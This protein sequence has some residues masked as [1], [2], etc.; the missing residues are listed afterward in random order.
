M[1]SLRRTTPYRV[2]RIK[3][4]WIK[5]KYGSATY[6]VAEVSCKFYISP[7]LT[8]L[9][10]YVVPYLVSYK[11]NRGVVSLP[12]HKVLFGPSVHVNEL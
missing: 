8:I 5:D 9:R 7:L 3:G 12:P 6:Q 4:E 2:L 1:Y 10:C 11:I